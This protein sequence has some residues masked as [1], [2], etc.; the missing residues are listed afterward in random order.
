MLAA[1]WLGRLNSL[2]PATSAV[3]LAARSPGRAA[4]KRRPSEHRRRG[5]RLPLRE[6]R[7]NA[8]TLTYR[9][10]LAH[11]RGPGVLRPGVSCSG[12]G[13]VPRPRPQA[14]SDIGRPPTH[15]RP[16]AFVA[17]RDDPIATPPGHAAEVAHQDAGECD[18]AA[19]LAASIGAARRR[20]CTVADRGVDEQHKLATAATAR[21]VTKEKSR[22]GTPSCR[23]T[24]WIRQR[25]Q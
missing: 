19:V 5:G 12:Q 6:S 25:S 1:T 17:G 2:S 10:R 7:K 4:P 20:Q 3:V 18:T 22:V 24:A 14:P 16:P 15:P 21:S 11:A 8:R 13:T 23:S 9:C